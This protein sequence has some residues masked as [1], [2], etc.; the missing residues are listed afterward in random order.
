[1]RDFEFT[2]AANGQ[3]PRTVKGDFIKVKSATIEL[4]IVAESKD[5]RVLADL[6]M[7]E[8]AQ[9]A[10]PVQFEKVRVENPTGSSTIAVL[11]LGNGEVSDNQLSGNVSV[12]HGTSLANAAHTVGTSAAELLA[13]SSTRNNILIKNRDATN[14]IYIGADNTVTTA[15]GFEIEAG[16]G[17]TIDKSPEAAI[18]AIGAAVGLDVRTLEE[19]A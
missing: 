11:I 8:G 5:G 7:S 18:W 10:L 3:D 1:M 15:N 13:A 16:Q 19:L 14:S 9:V 6:L 17:I 2:I 12:N 4:R